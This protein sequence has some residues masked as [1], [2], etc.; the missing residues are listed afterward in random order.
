MA[1]LIGYPTWS[2]MVLEHSMAGSVSN[3]MEFLET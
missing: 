2:E 3:V 1:N